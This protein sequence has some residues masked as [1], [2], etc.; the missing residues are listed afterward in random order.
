MRRARG[1]SKLLI[2]LGN[3]IVRRSEGHTCLFC[4]IC[5]EIS[6]AQIVQVVKVPQAYMTAIGQ[7]QPV[8]C[9]LQCDRC[10]TV[11]P[12]D[13]NVTPWGPDAPELLRR[14]E[15]ESRARDLTA[16]SEER[17]YLLTEVLTAL[18]YECVGG[19]RLGTNQGMTAMLQALTGLAVFI[20]LSLW[21]CY[22]GEGNDANKRAFLMWAAGVSIGTVIL[23]PLMIYCTIRAN[24]R[25]VQTLLLPRI[26]RSLVALDPLAQELDDILAEL[27]VGKAAVA[28]Y[29]TTSQVN[30]A[31]ELARRQP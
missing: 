2:Q 22:F 31:I 25:F 7:G 8:R 1:T 26:A 16:S 20:C 28:K 29:V 6:V 30:E 19:T 17:E 24:V 12:T 10:G 14:V 13:V 27:R 21:L 5:R 4:P 18:D 3:K 23:I 11:F 15:I 9:E